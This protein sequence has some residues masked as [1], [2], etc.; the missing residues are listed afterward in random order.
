[1]QFSLAHTIDIIS[2]TPS[3][4]RSLLAGLPDGWLFNNEGEGTWS[5]FDVVGHLI[6]CEKTDFIPRTE[7]ILSGKENRLMEPLD[8]QAHF[9]YGRGKTM[10]DL[11]KEFEKL[12]AEN[13]Q[14]LIDMKLTETDLQQTGIHPRIGEISLQNLL[15]TWVV[16][17]MGHL[18]QIA[19]VLAKQYKEEVGTFNH[20]LT[21]LK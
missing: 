8:M 20:F 2:R 1:M 14:K 16:H 4:V 15:A 11:L 19:R 12:R 18:A 7:L 10:E 17:D 13:I 9:V 5:P 21:I 6:V 3:V